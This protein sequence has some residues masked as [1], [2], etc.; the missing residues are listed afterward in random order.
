MK[1][2]NNHPTFRTRVYHASLT[3][4]RTLVLCSVGLACIAIIGYGIGANVAGSSAGNGFMG[5]GLV[6]MIL[7]ALFVGPTHQSSLK[8]TDEAVTWNTGRQTLTIPWQAVMKFDADP[9]SK[10]WFRHAFIHDGTRT[11]VVSSYVF[12][13]YDQIVSLLEVAMRTHWRGAGTASSK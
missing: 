10:R 4:E 12:R 3:T 11:I 9:P 13:E 7:A 5:L 8:I 2:T 1:A 6:L